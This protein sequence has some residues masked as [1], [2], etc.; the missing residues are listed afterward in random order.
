VADL[1]GTGVMLVFN[2]KFNGI[3]QLLSTPAPETT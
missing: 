1:Q 2:D 3:L